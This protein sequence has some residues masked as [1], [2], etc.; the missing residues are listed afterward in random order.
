M[1]AHR[2]HRSRRWRTRARRGLARLGR[3]LKRT[4]LRLLAL[5]LA[6]ALA[7]DWLEARFEAR[8]DAGTHH[9]ALAAP[10]ASTAIVFTGGSERIQAALD[11]LSDGQLQRLLISGVNPGAGLDPDHLAARVTLSDAQAAALANGDVTLGTDATN[12]LENARE[13]AC[14]L[15]KQPQTRNALLLTSGSHLPRAAL[16]LERAAP[17]GVT[18]LAR[19]SDPGQGPIDKSLRLTEFP[20]FVATWVITLL[21]TEFWSPRTPALCADPEPGQG[22]SAAAARH[23]LHKLR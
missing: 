7:L 2:R 12:T 3:R 16:A 23:P 18:I 1:A 15:A 4:T 17:A 10:A 8:L 6:L 13:A 21:P 5:T 9:A 20:K 11:L 14:W 19:R 22:P